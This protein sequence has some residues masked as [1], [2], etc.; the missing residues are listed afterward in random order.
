VNAVLDEID[1]VD[2]T[3]G[4]NDVE[5]IIDMDDEYQIQTN[6]NTQISNDFFDIKNKTIE[7]QSEDKS[8]EK[9]KE[10]KIQ[11][12]ILVQRRNTIGLI[13]FIRGKYKVDNPNYIIKLFNMMTFDEKRMFRE[14]DSFD[15]LRTIIGLKKEFNIKIMHPLNSFFDHIF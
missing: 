11:K 2:N 4:I 14:Y 1:G 3:D 12:V 13:E 15:M 7:K 8:K 9:M 10:I 6:T 5:E